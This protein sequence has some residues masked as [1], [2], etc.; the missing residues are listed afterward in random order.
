MT[1]KSV[2]ILL[3]PL[4]TTPGWSQQADNIQVGFELDALPFITGGYYGS[5][6]VGHKHIRYR[7]IITE[8]TTPAF[9]V[10]EGFTNNT[11]NA[12]TAI[13]D[14]FFKPDFKKWW[15]GAG[16]EYWQGSIQSDVKIS[17]S[18]YENIIATA[19][20]GYVWKFYKNFYLNPWTALHL[21]VAGDK[22]VMVDSQEFNPPVVTPEV[23]LKIGWHF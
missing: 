10:E 16:I 12:Y 14:Y 9:F 22:K 19:G 8:I 6:W 5:V 18:E 2:L 20:T 23:S 1:I 11:I 4:T 15:V 3:I 13:V 17:T 21:R 7:A